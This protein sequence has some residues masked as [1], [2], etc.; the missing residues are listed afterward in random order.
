[1]YRPTAQNECIVH[2]FARLRGMCLRRDALEITSCGLTSRVS[3]GEH[4]YV[5]VYLRRVH[6]RISIYVCISLLE[7]IIGQRTSRR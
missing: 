4:F 5:Y 6:T 3:P 1:M 2:R 7:Q